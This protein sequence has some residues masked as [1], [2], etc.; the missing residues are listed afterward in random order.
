MKKI[1]KFIYVIVTALLIFQCASDDSNTQYTPPENLDISSVNDMY[2]YNN[3]GNSFFE[4]YGTAT[5]WRWN[6]NFIAP[7]ERATPI[8]SEFV[9]PAARLIDYLWIEPFTSVGESGKKF[10]DEFFPPELVFIGSGIF[11]EEGVKLGFEEGGARVSLLR[12]NNL[13]FKDRDWL[14]DPTGGIITTIH[15]EFSHVIQRIYGNPVGLNT[16]SEKY[17]GIEWI[18]TSFDEAIKLG[19]V[20][21]YGASAEDDDFAEIVS[22][23]LVIDEAVF[24]ENYI[25]QEDCS[26]FSDPDEVLN[27]Q[28]LNTGR[29]LIKQK[30]D[31]IIEYYKNRVDIDLVEVKNTVQERLDN[32]LATGVIPD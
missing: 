25:T 29:Q 19:M 13:D 14:T 7:D 21:P 24:N 11:V 28:E 30:L 5:R 10:I 16:I 22:F 6:D 12:L 32:L 3:S 23:F 15:H 27:C 4:R 18:N 26:T 20:S 17:V 9:I 1:T 8:R 2:L 31:L